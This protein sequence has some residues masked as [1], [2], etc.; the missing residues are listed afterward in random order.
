LVREAKKRETGS[1]RA[2]GDLR[3]WIWVLGWILDSEISIFFTSIHV[4]SLFYLN[5]TFAV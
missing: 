2:E 1:I 5:V 3:W 4:F